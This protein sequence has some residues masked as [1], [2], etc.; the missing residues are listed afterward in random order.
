MSGSVGNTDQFDTE[1]QCKIG[2]QCPN[3]DAKLVS[4]TVYDTGFTP[5]TIELHVPFRCPVGSV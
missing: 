1:V 4:Y 5:M 2:V 3:V